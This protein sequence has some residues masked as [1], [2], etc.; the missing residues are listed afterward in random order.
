MCGYT[1]YTVYHA[2]AESALPGAYTGIKSAK[3]RELNTS[4]LQQYVRC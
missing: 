3:V 2:E 1:H 4:G